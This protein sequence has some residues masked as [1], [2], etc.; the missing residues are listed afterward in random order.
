[1]DKRENGG[2]KNERKSLFEMVK[3]ILGGKGKAVEAEGIPD[4]VPDMAS[5]ERLIGKAVGEADGGRVGGSGEGSGEAGKRG[6]PYATKR[7]IV[8]SLAAIRRFAEENE[9]ASTVVRSLLT[10]LA[11]MALDAL[12]GKVGI[13]AL[14]TLLKAFNYDSARKEAF[15]EGEKAGRNARIKEEVFPPQETI[16]PDIN[17]SLRKPSRGAS[18]F[19]IAEGAE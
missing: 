6:C 7:A 15:R 11:E 8:E 12:K 4:Q 19:E 9:L 13:K 10:L 16:L 5:A 14:E 3:E 1:M 17:G 2:K 18:I